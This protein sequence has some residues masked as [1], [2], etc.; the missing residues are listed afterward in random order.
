MYGTYVHGIFDKEGVV[1]AILKAIG[2]K[3]GIDSSKMKAVD[4]QE[5]KEKQYNIL[6]DTLRVHLDLKKIYQILEE[7]I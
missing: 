6:A 2:E 4:Y 1:N 5:F 7:G 3:K